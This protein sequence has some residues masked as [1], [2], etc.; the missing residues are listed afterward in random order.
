[1]TDSLYGVF[2]VFSLAGEDALL[3]EV[4]KLKAYVF[5]KMWHEFKEKVI[6]M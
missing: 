3:V 6:L 5:V 4:F 2:A 1:M